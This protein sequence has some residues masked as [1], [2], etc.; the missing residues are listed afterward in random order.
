[1]SFKFNRPVENIPVGCKFSAGIGVCHCPDHIDHFR[2][3]IADPL[4]F[5]FCI[6]KNEYHFSCFSY[7]KSINAFALVF[8]DDSKYQTGEFFILLCFHKPEKFQFMK[9]PNFPF[10]YLNH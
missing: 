8:R 5:I 4:H 3:E 2:I 9:K 1:M 10:R 6:W 7:H